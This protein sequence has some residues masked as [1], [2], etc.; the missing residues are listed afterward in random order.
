LTVIRQNQRDPA[1]RDLPPAHPSI[2]RFRSRRN[3]LDSRFDVV[4]LAEPSD[5]K[6]VVLGLILNIGHRRIG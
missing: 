6:H 5:Y 4:P 2:I 3:A 1:L